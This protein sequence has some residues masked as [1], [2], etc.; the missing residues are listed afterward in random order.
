[1][2]RVLIAGSGRCVGLSRMRRGITGGR[3]S[4][5]NKPMVPTAPTSLNSHPPVPLRRHIGQP[6]S[7]QDMRDT[8]RDV[9]L[10]DSHIFSDGQFASERHRRCACGC[11]VWRLCASCSNESTRA[12]RKTEDCRSISLAL[13][14]FDLLPKRKCLD[15]LLHVFPIRSTI[16]LDGEFDH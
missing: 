2:A 15:V 5:P 16:G 7:V 10:G 13:G 14:S 12:E 3:V 4:M 9:K 8:L 1:M 6:F 11:V